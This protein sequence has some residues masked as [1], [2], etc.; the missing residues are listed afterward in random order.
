MVSAGSSLLNSAV[1][2]S[3]MTMIDTRIIARI[4][5]YYSVFAYTNID[6]SCIICNVIIK[7]T[8]KLLTN[9]LGY[10]IIVIKKYKISDLS[11]LAAIGNMTILFL[12]TFDAVCLFYSNW[13]ASFFA[14]IKCI[15]IYK[16][17]AVYS[18]DI[19]HRYF[20]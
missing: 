13:L 18:T 11:W 12:F 20:T 3:K 5:L 7:P 10:F 8:L 15:F 4:I 9:I 6:I 2:L 1:F 17:F 16:F 19:F 14:Q